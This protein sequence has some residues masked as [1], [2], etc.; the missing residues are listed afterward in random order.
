MRAPAKLTLLLDVGPRQGSGLHP[1]VGVFQSV[2][3]C[4]EVAIGPSDDWHLSV[5]GPASA[6]VP[7]ADA[8]LAMRA[9]RAFAALH[10]AEAQGVTLELEKRIPVGGG[11]GGGS[12]DAAAVLLGLNEATGGMI[13]RKALEK[14][15]ATLGSDVPFCVRGGTVVVEGTGERLTTLPVRE[16][17]H[18][19]L[20]PSSVACSTAEVY[21]RF[22]AL[23]DG[24][25]PDLR[26]GPQD[27]ADALARGEL[28]RIAASLSNDLEPAALDLH[29]AL[30]AGRE[31]LER[32]GAL[33]VVLA[34]SGS[35]WAGLC[36]DAAHAGTLAES[37]GGIAVASLNHGPAS[38]EDAGPP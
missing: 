16:V 27:L 33:G 25:A 7:A 35:T 1:V 32:V 38:V 37:V 29:P 14:L 34:G 31:R 19:V 9:A 24:R 3:L 5:S 30:A 6:G 23:G 11:L 13:S 4:D 28:D 17:L 10:F 21:G 20:L 15:A 18:W 8:N 36:R 2:S 26:A 22:D 12:S